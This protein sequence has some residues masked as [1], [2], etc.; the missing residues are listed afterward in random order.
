MV[1]NGA[2]V[3][4]LI[5]GSAIAGLG[6][7][8]RLVTLG[9]VL[10]HD[11]IEVKT[12]PIPTTLFGSMVAFA[13]FQRD[14]RSFRPDLLHVHYAGGR[15]GSLALASGMRPLVVTVMGGDVQP[16]QLMGRATPGDH[17]ATERILAEA[18]L[19]LS[20]STAL[21]TDI[22]KY[23][24]YRDKIETVRWG[25]EVGRF[26]RD[27]EKG[28]VLR[29]RLGVG[30]GP[31]LFSP[32]ILR[33]HYNIHLIVEAMPE[34]RAHHPGATL[35]LS[36]HREDETY[37]GELRGQVGRLGMADAVR[38]LD[39]VTYEDMPAMLSM[40]DVV[41]SVPFSDGLPQTLFECLAS[42]TPIVL[43]RLDAYEEM[44]HDG[45]EV[46]LAELN[47]EGIAA[48]VRR[49][50]ADP[51]LAASLRANGLRRIR[52]EPSLSDEARRVEG[53]YQRILA[54]PRRKSPLWP[55]ILDAASLA[56]K[57]G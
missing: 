50:L 37:A 46:V 8:V 29:A 53:F 34:I 11:G 25:I 38:F 33:R 57:R 13:S 49:V 55:R 1:G 43:G 5:R 2:T 22:A 24:D 20:K 44:V 18:D 56:G 32:R 28:A 14:L 10:A 15:L 3:H 42:E 19:I 45:R 16:E 23:G 9:P 52:Q 21:R 48:A 7:T 41:V 30:P 54:K 17:R 4:A 6:H 40:T 26:A 12:R 47:P 39:P 31:V 35:L 36:R 27:P 51:A